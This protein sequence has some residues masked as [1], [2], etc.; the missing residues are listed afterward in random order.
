MALFSDDLIST[1]KREG[2]YRNFTDIPFVA[3]QSDY[4]LPTYA[5]YGKLESVAYLDQNSQLLPGQLTRIEVENLQDVL[6]T[7]NTGIPRFFSVNS[8]YITV[9]PPPTTAT[10]ASIRVWYDRR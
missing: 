10:G 9:Y 5:M 7:L 4:A 1:V 2:F 8:S 6:P 3:N